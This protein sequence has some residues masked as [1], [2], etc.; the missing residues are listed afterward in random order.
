[1]LII[2]YLC[3][4]W[5]WSVGLPAAYHL[6]IQV[7]KSQRAD[8][9]SVALAQSKVSGV[10]A[11]LS[12]SILSRSLHKSTGSMHINKTF[13]C[14]WVPIIIRHQIATEVGKCP[15]LTPA[16][17][18]FLPIRDCYSLQVQKVIREGSISSERKCSGYAFKPFPWTQLNAPEAN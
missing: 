18:Q 7:L 5:F 6:W 17:Q 14:P 13:T 2:A 8:R 1:M 10:R 15:S 3:M 16:L 11:I 4:W 9:A 12:Y